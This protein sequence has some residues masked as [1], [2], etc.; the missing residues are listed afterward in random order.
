MING[1]HDNDLVISFQGIGLINTDLVDPVE[2]LSIF[3]NREEELPK[4]VSSLQF[5]SVDKNLPQQVSRFPGIR[6]RCVGRSVDGAE[7]NEFAFDDLASS[8]LQPE[9]SY[10][11][12][13]IIKRC[14]RELSLCRHC[15]GSIS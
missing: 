15:G 14:M 10:L 3:L 13:S 2:E 8:L 9:E 6:K 1:G 5:S 4:V 11:I 12:G 7:V